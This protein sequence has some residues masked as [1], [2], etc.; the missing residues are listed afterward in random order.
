MTASHISHATIG[1]VGGRSVV[2]AYGSVAA[3]YE[4]LQSGAVIIDR[5]HRGRLRVSGERAAEMVTGLVTNDVANLPPGQGC[6]AAALTAKGKIVADIR[7]F[8]DEGSV[9]TDAPPRAAAAWAGMVKKFIN[10]RIA[11]H[12]DET[13][14]LRDLGVFGRDARLVVSAITGVQ[15]PSLTVLAPY[16]HVSVELDGTR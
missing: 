11:P 16:A 7:V 3:E 8:V 12:V 14:A 6:Y 5:S 13:S 2:L 15:S 1:D 10:P 9:L 4:A